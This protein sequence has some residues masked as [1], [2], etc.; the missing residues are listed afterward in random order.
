LVWVFV[1]KDLNFGGTTI[2]YFLL[3]PRHLLFFTFLLMSKRTKTA[4]TEVAAGTK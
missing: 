4:V 1:V 2:N 3:L